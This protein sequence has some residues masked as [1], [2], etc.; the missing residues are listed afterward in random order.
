MFGE[1][2]QQGR[3]GRTAVQDDHGAHAP[4]DG[5]Q[6]RLGLGDHAARDGAVLGHLADLACLQLGHDLTFGVLHAGHIGQQQQPVGL[7]RG[8][9]GT[10][11]GVAVD[12]ERLARAAC[13][14]GGGQSRG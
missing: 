9:D 10:G 3:I 2:L 14:D 5:V 1:Q 7:E 6:R 13:T 11:G 12:V 4:V 8:G